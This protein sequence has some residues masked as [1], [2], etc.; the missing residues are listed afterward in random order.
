[1]AFTKEH[2][3][4]L[5]MTLGWV[6]S[7]AFS[8]YVLV[9]SV[10]MND[11]NVEYTIGL[12][13]STSDTR[14]YELVIGAP[15]LDH[16]DVSW[17]I[18]GNSTKYGEEYTL[19]EGSF[20]FDDIKDM[21]DK[22][23][24]ENPA[25]KFTGNTA[26]ATVSVGQTAAQP[27][28]VKAVDLETL[29]SEKMDSAHPF[30]QTSIASACAA[31]TTPQ[32]V[33]SYAGFEPCGKMLTLELATSEDT[34]HKYNGSFVSASCADDV[35]VMTELSSSGLVS[36]ALTFAMDVGIKSLH[37]IDDSRCKK[38]TFHD[39]EP[40]A[41]H[42]VE[43]IKHY[44]AITIVLST[45]LGVFFVVKFFFPDCLSQKNMIMNV[46]SI[47]NFEFYLSYITII[48]VV[49]LLSM[50]YGNITHLQSLLEH[51]EAEFEKGDNC[52][53]SL[54]SDFNNQDVV[55]TALFSVSVAMYGLAFLV[56]PFVYMNRDN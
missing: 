8:I 3:P 36:T 31:Q 44:A 21:F 25:K 32:T 46:L 10:S 51:D 38:T 41:S 39:N 9:Q 43:L 50:T 29:F 20:G 42:A 19:C 15:L 48:A 28:T 4:R 45:L 40:K 16:N 11:N 54:S 35:A 6:F 34:P 37:L 5:W 52:K 56:Y 14:S 30:A 12:N 49:I 53:Y 47:E 27:N 33:T 23:D 7:V 26:I 22:P 2:I 18:K 13:H 24:K 1:M 17:K 55:F